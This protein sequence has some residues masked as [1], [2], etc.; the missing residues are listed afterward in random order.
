MIFDVFRFRWSKNNNTDRDPK[1]DLFDV[2]PSKMKL[3]KK[4]FRTRPNFPTKTD[5][6]QSANQ[7]SSSDHSQYPKAIS[8]P[9]EW[10]IDFISYGK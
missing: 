7:K 4:K 3:M 1:V 6:D 2:Q 10:L 8:E 9:F 5:L